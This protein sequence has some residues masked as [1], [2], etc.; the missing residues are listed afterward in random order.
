MPSLPLVAAAPPSTRSRI[1]KARRGVAAAGEGARRRQQNAARAQ[2]K[3]G[4][5]QLRSSRR[6]LPAKDHRTDRSLC[7]SESLC[8]DEK[9]GQVVFRPN[10]SNGVFSWMERNPEPRA[11]T[12]NLGS[13]L[14]RDFLLKCSID[15]DNLASMG[16]A[17]FLLRPPNPNPKAQRERGETGD[18]FVCFRLYV[19]YILLTWTSP[20]EP[21][22]YL[23]MLFIL[24]VARWSLH[25]L[26]LPLI[27][28]GFGQARASKRRVAVA[29]VSHRKDVL[30]HES[31]MD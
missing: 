29:A 6:R 28:F 7:I 22:L 10:T 19:G 17:F 20:S 2:R 14:P 16:D 15:F 26:P 4:N 18:F 25:S 1:R 27:V 3:D 8:A 13:S 5:D 30:M 11:A 23:F 9:M 31:R 21:L 24:V 12:C